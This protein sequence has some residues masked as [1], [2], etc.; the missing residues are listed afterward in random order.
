MKKNIFLF[1]E[2]V[3]YNPHG[4]KM[5]PIHDACVRGD[6]DGVKLLLQDLDTR[7]QD[8]MLY[9]Q[10]ENGNNCFILAFINKHYDLLRFICIG[11]CEIELSLR[12]VYDNLVNVCNLDNTLHDIINEY[13]VYT[14]D[15]EEEYTEEY[16]IER[17]E[18]ELSTKPHLLESRGVDYNT[19]LHEACEYR[20]F[21]V[22]KLLLEK[23]ADI[24]SFNVFLQ[25]PIHI[26]SHLRQSDDN[27]E[28]ITKLLLLLLEY[29]A[30]LYAKDVYNET[31]CDKA[32][33]RRIPFPACY[34]NQT[35]TSL[36]RAFSQVM[37]KN[38][39]NLKTSLEVT[40]KQN[41][42]TPQV[43]ELLIHAS[44]AMKQLEHKKNKS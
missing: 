27:P 37:I 1:K 21:G 41:V 35:T 44:I 13:S 34:Y 20:L 2:S 39:V 18:A 14:S 23:G 9:S 24:N 6:I 42:L 31:S 32:F 26:I 7:S 15:D 29:G 3:I 36:Q 19:P 25:Q 22:V 4:T 16:I 11:K 43:Q 28:K 30:D 8:R 12:N 33:P 40:K 38:M 5:A 17:I 10:D